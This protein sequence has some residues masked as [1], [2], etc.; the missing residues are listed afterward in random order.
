M[1]RQYPILKIVLAVWVI[2]SFLYVGYTQ[3][4]YFKNYVAASSYQR[5]LSDA[6]G[7]VIQQAQKCEAFPIQRDG[8]GVNLI[9][10]ACVPPVNNDKPAK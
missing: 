5:G 7:K 6:V 4:Q 9:N 10:A 8:Q 3:Y 2:F 1:K